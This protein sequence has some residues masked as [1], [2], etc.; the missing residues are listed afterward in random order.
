ML[1]RCVMYRQMGY[2]RW[3]KLLKSRMVRYKQTLC[4]NRDGAVSRA[5]NPVSVCDGAK[6]DGARRDRVGWG[7]GV[8]HYRP[9]HDLAAENC[10]NQTPR[11]EKFP[12]PFVNMTL[13]GNPN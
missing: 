9:D 10:F 1:E 5:K 7:G 4:T 3:V 11:G 12:H 2:C 8:S 13:R 6:Q